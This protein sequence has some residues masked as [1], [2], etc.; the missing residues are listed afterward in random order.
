MVSE[1]GKRKGVTETEKKLVTVEVTEDMKEVLDRM[2]EHN[3][4]AKH[5][6][7]ALSQTTRFRHQFYLLWKR[8]ERREADKPRI[9]KAKYLGE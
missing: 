3:I 5:V 8:L 6:A 1:R 2:E 4:D 7:Y 9:R